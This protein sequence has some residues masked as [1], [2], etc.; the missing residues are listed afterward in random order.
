MNTL[1]AAAAAVGAGLFLATGGV[2]QQRQAS[3]R[4]SG[5]G[6]KLFWHLVTN[7]LWL[8]GIGAAVISYGLQ[9]VALSYGTL[10]LVQPLIVSELLFAVPFSVRLRGLRLHA[11]EWLA[12]GAVVVGLAV[13]IVAANPHGGDPL[14]PFTVWIP[15]L[16]GVLVLAAASLFAARVVHGPVKASAFA[17]AGA[18]VMGMQTALYASTIALIRQG[19]WQVFLHWQPYVLVVASIAGT[20]LIQKSFQA[21]PLAASTPVIDATLPIVAIT[22]GVW[23]FNE[24]VRTSLFGLTGGVVGVI[25]LIAGIIL[26]DTSPVV[27]REEQI[28]EEQQ[29]KTV[30]E[31]HKTG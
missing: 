4:P 8:L 30:E 25:L 31:E 27:R 2:I 12:C 19:F 22:L 17:F 11:R 18:V 13:G 6:V 15:A 3:Q 1:I 5:E 7:R 21:G 9:A 29:E 16:I 20:L 14:Q 24:Q 23:L 10:V 26:L 28:E